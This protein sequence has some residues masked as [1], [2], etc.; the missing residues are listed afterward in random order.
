MIIDNHAAVGREDFAIDVKFWSGRK[1][2]HPQIINK[3]RL[4]G[5]GRSGF[6]PSAPR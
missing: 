4:K 5:F 3:G 2:C 1:I 6:Q